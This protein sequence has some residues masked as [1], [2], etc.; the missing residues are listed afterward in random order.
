MDILNLS[1][2]SH[3]SGAYQGCIS[4]SFSPSAD[5]GILPVFEVEQEHPFHIVRKA[6][7][8]SRK[9]NGHSFR[10]CFTLP[11]DQNPVDLLSI[12]DVVEAQSLI[13]SLTT[14]KKYLAVPQSEGTIFVVDAWDVGY[15][16]HERRLRFFLK[17]EADETWL[18]ARII[19]ILPSDWKV[20]DL[21]GIRESD[22]QVFEE[23]EN[24]KHGDVYP[25]DIKAGSGIE[26]FLWVLGL[27]RHG[28]LQD[29][30][31]CAVTNGQPF[32]IVGMF[33]MQ[34]IKRII[35]YSEVRSGCYGTSDNGTLEFE[36]CELDITAT[37]WDNE[38]CDWQV[39][40]VRREGLSKNGHKWLIGG[41][42]DQEE[43]RTHA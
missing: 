13:R 40:L 36:F 10:K 20:V 21:H 14:I 25:A 30:A 18:I 42:E 23:A 4:R 32:T 35:S 34:S 2:F 26:F 38:I 3:S 33:L 29:F 19:K 6:F 37:N 12:P 15:I 27:A 43:G 5:D 11:P 22:E 28:E 8:L 1:H 41:L 7:E 16:E 17:K 9:K 31:R 39:H 24:E